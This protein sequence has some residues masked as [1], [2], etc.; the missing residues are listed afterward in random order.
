MG[1]ERRRAEEKAGR[2]RWEEGARG[3][4]DSRREKGKEGDERGVE[5]EGRKE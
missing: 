4:G 5:M 3:D 1:I 2:S